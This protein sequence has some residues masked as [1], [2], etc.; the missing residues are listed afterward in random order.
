MVKANSQLG[1]ESIKVFRVCLV[2]RFTQA[3]VGLCTHPVSGSPMDI[4]AGATP[5][6]SVQT[7]H[8]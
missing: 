5:R 7:E 3:V 4:L 8:R 6:L 2:C 1:N